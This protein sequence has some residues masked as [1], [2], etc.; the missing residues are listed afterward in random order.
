MN[1]QESFYIF[2]IEFYDYIYPNKKISD[3]KKI[4]YVNSFKDKILNKDYRTIENIKNF[5]ENKQMHLAYVEIQNKKAQGNM[6]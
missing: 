3:I 4:W 1:S 5:Y 2:A 6:V